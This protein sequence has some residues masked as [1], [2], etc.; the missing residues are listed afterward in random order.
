MKDY[1]WT[2]VLG[3]RDSLLVQTIEDDMSEV[4]CDYLGVESEEDITKQ[5][6]EELLEVRKLL[7]MPAS[8]GGMGF[9][10]DNSIHFEFLHH[11]IQMLAD[12]I[13]Q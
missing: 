1:N 10:F 13:T 6:I 9:T 3:K 11:S 4:I 5:N 12:E 7:E 2:R 8:D